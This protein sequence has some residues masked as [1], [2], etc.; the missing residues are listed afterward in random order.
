MFAIGGDED[1]L[2][3]ALQ[4]RGS[5]PLCMLLLWLRGAG[6]LSA[7]LQSAATLGNDTWVRTA[8]TAA[9][10][11]APAPCFLPPALPLRRRWRAI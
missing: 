2:R 5:S 10:A 8:A 4:V 7:V 6:P 3:H 11:E 9:S 1:E